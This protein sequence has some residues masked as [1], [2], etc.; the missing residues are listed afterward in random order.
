M[1]VLRGSCF[2]KDLRCPHSEKDLCAA[3]LWISEVLPVWEEFLGATVLRR[4]L[5][6]CSVGGDSEGLHI[7]KDFGGR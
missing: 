2:A 7:E 1:R 5:R 4:I 3:V 6:C